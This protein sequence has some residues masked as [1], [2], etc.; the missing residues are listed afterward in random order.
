M[1]EKT[2]AEVRYW[3]HYYKGKDCF[4]IIPSQDV[5]KYTLEINSE[6]QLH[7]SGFR[8]VAKELFDLDISMQC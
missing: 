8:D 1:Y 4:L 7:S 5:Q 6:D 3:Y 2:H